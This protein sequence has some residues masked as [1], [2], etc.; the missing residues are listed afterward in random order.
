MQDSKQYKDKKSFFEKVI[1]LYGRNVVIEILED[2]TISIH[3][4]HMSESN[5]T[6]DSIKKILSLAKKRDIELIFHNKTALSRI[7][8]N[9]KHDQGVA[10]DIISNLIKILKNYKS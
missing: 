5:K 8:K 3:K 1:T 10:I 2:K 7:S 4:L 6:D 9:A